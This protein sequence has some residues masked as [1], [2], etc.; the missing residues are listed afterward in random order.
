M[1]LMILAKTVSG[2]R[3][4]V[5]EYE[6]S[7]SQFASLSLSVSS[8][9]RAE[10]ALV[11]RAWEARGRRG[12]DRYADHPAHLCF[13]TALHHREGSHQSLTAADGT[14]GRFS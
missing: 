14:H 4:G 10:A 1:A 3:R 11:L 8:R 9:Y 2:A 6:R 7:V 13:A 5:G 12:I